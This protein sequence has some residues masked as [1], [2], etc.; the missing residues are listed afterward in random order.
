MKVS[1]RCLDLIKEFEGFS[2]IPYICPAGKNT[3]GYGHAIQLGEFFTRINEEEAEDL[4]INDIAGAERCVNVCVESMINQNQFDA[5]VSFVYN[6]G[7]GAFQK[8]SM[9]RML[10]SGDY[11]GAARQFSRWINSNGKPLNGLIRRRKAEKALFEEEYADT[12]S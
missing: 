7:S 6:V 1:K 5:L 11:A 4:L 8:S 10:N 9:L 2:A 3:I 12:N